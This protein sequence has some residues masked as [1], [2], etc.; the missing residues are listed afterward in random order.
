M[1]RPLKIGILNIMHDNKNTRHRFEEI[2]ASL[3]VPIDLTFFYPTKYPNGKIPERI[4]RLAQPLDLKKVPNFDA[5]IITGSPIERFPFEDITYIDEVY[6]LIDALRVNGIEQLYLC[7]GAMAALNYLYNIGKHELPEK[8][9]G[10]FPEKILKPSPLLTGIRQNFLA[11]HARYWESNRDEIEEN[12][13]LEINAVSDEG[14][15]FLVTAPDHP[16]QSFLFSHLEYGRRG[17]LK[18]YQRERE[19]HPDRFYKKPENYLLDPDNLA[20][21]QYQWEGV[22]RQFF[23]NWIKQIIKNQEIS[24]CLAE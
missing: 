8:V 7:W 20:E 23:D 22:R 1:G 19:A 9:F 11:P 17:L 6:H 4:T 5:F 15:L 14:H 16:H 18:E 2:F 13:E 10:I 21:P 24:Y 12:P 3:S